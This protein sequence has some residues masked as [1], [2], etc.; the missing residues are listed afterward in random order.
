VNVLEHPSLNSK[1][2][3]EDVPHIGTLI[4]VDLPDAPG[5][6]FLK[7]RCGTGRWFAES[8]NDKRYNTAL[9][10]NAAG[11][12]YRGVGNPEDFIPFART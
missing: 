9:L 12:G 6:W 11:N 5:Q 1:I 4:Q 7:Y 10:A 3:N 2:I 8:V